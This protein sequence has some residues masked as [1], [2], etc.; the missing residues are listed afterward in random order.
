MRRL[1]LTKGFSNFVRH[2]LIAAALICSAALVAPAYAQTA[3][4]TGVPSMKDF[5]GANELPD[6]SLDYKIAFDVNTMAES[7]DQVSPALKMIG[8]LI[9]TYEQH[10]VSPD[11]LHLQAVFHGPT[12]ALVVDDATYK[13]RTGVDHNP[14]VDLLRQLQKAGLKM[15]VCGQSAMAQH[16]DFK[17][18]LPLAQINLSA[19]VTFINLMTRGYIK[20]NE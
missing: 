12:I 6:P 7:P 19:S 16:Y 17:S 9:N 18:I 10:G 2:G 20:M 11:H 1:H 8:A 15:V 14:N 4:I 5:P 3:P 13:G